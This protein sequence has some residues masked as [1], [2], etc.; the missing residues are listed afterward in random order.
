MDSVIPVAYSPPKR[1]R[2]ASRLPPANTLA[3]KRLVTVDPLVEHGLLDSLRL[4]LGSCRCGS[5]WAACRQVRLSP[6][7]PLRQRVWTFKFSCEKLGQIHGTGR[8]E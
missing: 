2:I 6:R 1:H 5:L 3:P 4:D 8:Y 7:R